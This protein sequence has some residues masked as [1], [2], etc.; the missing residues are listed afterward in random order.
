MAAG[1]AREW[2]IANKY[3]LSGD[4]IIRHP[5]DCFVKTITLVMSRTEVS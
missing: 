3:N 2:I 5:G 4:R 1:M